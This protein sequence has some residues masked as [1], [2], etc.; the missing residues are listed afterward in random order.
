MPRGSPPALGSIAQIPRGGVG[1][2]LGVPVDPLVR[3]VEVLHELGRGRRRA[4][5]SPRS[6]SGCRAAGVL[7]R[8]ARAGGSGVRSPG[9]PPLQPGTPQGPDARNSSECL[10]FQLHA[11]RHLVR[12]GLPLVLHRE[13]ATRAGPGRLPAP[14]PGR[15]GLPLVPVAPGCPDGPQSD[16]HRAGDAR[17]QVRPD[18]RGGGREAGRCDRGGR[19]AGHGLEPPPRVP[20]RR[21]GRRAPA[22]PPRARRGRDH[23]AGRAQGRV[24]P[25]LL[26]RGAQRR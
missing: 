21:H 25:R 4:T 5:S 23:A 11:H 12:R 26:R 10:R 17:A 20:A 24:A 16:R 18:P 9:S 15:G 1:R 3:L 14:R 6:D 7:R 13:A 22:P 2:P 19:R 8:G